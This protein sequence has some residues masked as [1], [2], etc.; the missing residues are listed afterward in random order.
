VRRRAGHYNAQELATGQ[1][2]RFNRLSE[3]AADVM[4]ARILAGL[5]FRF[6]DRGRG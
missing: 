5:P 2:R 6:L 3:A 4:G 1:V